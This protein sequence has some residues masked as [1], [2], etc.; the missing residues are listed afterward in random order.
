MLNAAGQGHALIGYYGRHRS[1]DTIASASLD[2]NICIWD[3]YTNTCQQKLRG[4]RL[5]VVSLAYCPAQRLLVSAGF[6]H[7]ALVWSPFSSTVV[8]KLKGHNSSLV[9]VCR[10][11]DESSTELLT[12]DVDGVFKIWDV[13]NFKCIQTFEGDLKKLVGFT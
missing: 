7:D 12:A 11:G 2:K 8:S 3:L 10:M 4:H 1:L 13:R 9:K 5:G 6:D